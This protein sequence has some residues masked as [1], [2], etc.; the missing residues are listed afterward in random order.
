MHY[1]HKV[2]EGEKVSLGEYDPREH[3]GLTKEEAEA[4]TAELGKE[5]EELQALQ[6]GAAQTSLL[7]VLQGLDTSGKDGTIRCLSNFM[8]AQSCRVW[9]FKVPTA[10]ERAHDFL[11][12]VHAVTPEK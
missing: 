2:H 7:I 10:V 8:N 5:L 3:G 9:P 6:Y 4:K 12:R 1:A 11:W